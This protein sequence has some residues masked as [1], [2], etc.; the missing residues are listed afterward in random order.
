MIYDAV[1]ANAPIVQ[2]DIFHRIPRVDI[3]LTK[4]SVIEAGVAGI[5]ERRWED[6]IAG[7]G[8]PSPV[9]AVLPLKPVTG[10]VISQNCDT[11]RGP[12]ISLC[13]VDEFVE[14]IGKANEPRNVKR[15]VSLIRKHA[16]EHF[17]Y[18][19]LPEDPT[20][21]FTTRMGVDFRMVLQVPRE[22]LETLKPL[23]LARLNP[24]AS[25]H[26]RESIAHFFRRYP[27]NEWYPLTKDEFKAYSE[28]SSEPVT[29]Y[30]WQRDTASDE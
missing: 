7:N 18:F 1:E 13:Q 15:W 20:I 14:I 19:Y 9:A 26:F 8:P 11:V 4:L 6:L 25:E 30:P 17:R 10:I 23:R 22:D 21:G 2:G 5:T 24:L 28:D 29:P 16:K 27:Y 3:S 12:Y